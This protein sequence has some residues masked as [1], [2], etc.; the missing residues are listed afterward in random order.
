MRGLETHVGLCSTE[1]QFRSDDVGQ[2][3]N[4]F[5]RDRAFRTAVSVWAIE[6]EPPTVRIVRPSAAAVAP[7][8][9]MLQLASWLCLVASYGVLAAVLWAVSR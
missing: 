8:P 7:T 3:R 2:W 5:E 1:P 4:S 9:R 6:N